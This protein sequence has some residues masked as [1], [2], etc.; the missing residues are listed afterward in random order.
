[1]PR[2][3]PRLAEVRPYGRK[4]GAKNKFT[5]LK[6]AFLNSFKEIGGE[7]ALSEWAKDPKNRGLFYQILSKLL[8]AHSDLNIENNPI[9]VIMP[10]GNKKANEDA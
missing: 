3:N 4:K 8:P 1:M 10:K 9:L 5:D 6:T 7:K 2:G